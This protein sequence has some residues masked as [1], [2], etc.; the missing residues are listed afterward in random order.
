MKMSQ[1]SPDR[2]RDCHGMRV[3]VP[4]TR[5]IF[6]YLGDNPNCPGYAIT[7]HPRSVFTVRHKL[8]ILTLRPD[9]PRAWNA[10]GTIP[11]TATAAWE[12]SAVQLS[13]EDG[14]VIGGGTFDSEKEA[15][16]WVA[17]GP[18]RFAYVRMVGNS[19]SPS[20]WTALSP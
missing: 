20:E 4:I 15:L 7:L 11:E 19:N 3:E 5:A 8:Q 12:Y 10:N 9:L 17:Q 16:A 6:I 14:S 13:P 2:R 1:L 18:D